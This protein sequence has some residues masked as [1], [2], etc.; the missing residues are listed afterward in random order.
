LAQNGGGT[1]LFLAPGT[2]IFFPAGGVST[3]AVEFLLV[4]GGGGGGRG[5]VGPGTGGGGGAGGFVTGS[6]IIGKTT[7]T[8]KV[9]AGGSGGTTSGFGASMNGSASSFIG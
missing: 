8:V 1:L 5:S 2:A 3:L 9:G 4:G 6:G 7:Y